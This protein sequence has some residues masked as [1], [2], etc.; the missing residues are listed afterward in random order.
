MDHLGHLPVAIHRA[1]DEK[2]L[3]D[4]RDRAQQGL[5]HS[6]ARYRAFTGNPSY[7]ICRCSLDG[8]FL[9]VNVAM[10]KMLGY[11]SAEELSAVNLGSNLLQD[12]GKLV[13]LV[14]HR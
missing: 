2:T 3:R 10:V 6:E 7:G 14:M 9:E 11:A 8:K 4:E 13:Q 1:L 12:P 5:R